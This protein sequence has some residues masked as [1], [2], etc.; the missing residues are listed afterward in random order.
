MAIRIS[1]PVVNFLQT[2]GLI[3]PHCR[4]V[5]LFIPP[6]GAMVLR[7]EV[8]VTSDSARILSEAF[9]MIADDSPPAKGDDE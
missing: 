2:R 9:A 4:E 5:S 7:Y 1:T 6:A 8:F 3:P